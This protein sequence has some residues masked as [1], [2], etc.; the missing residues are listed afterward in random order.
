MTVR[1]LMEMLAQFS[2]DLE[3]RFSDTYE[4]SEGWESG[5]DTA[6]CAIDEV[7]FDVAEC[8]V[9]LENIF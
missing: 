6:T 4:R 2:P 3:V 9:V 5:H 7:H 1:E 8:C